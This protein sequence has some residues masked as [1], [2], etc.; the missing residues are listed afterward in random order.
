MSERALVHEPRRCAAKMRGLAYRL[1]RGAT[2][3]RD[4]QQSPD[5]AD[6]SVS[7]IRPAVTGTGWK[8]PSNL[9]QGWGAVQMFKSSFTKWLHEWETLIAT[10]INAVIVIGVAIFVTS[11]VTN[12]QKRTEFFI[13]F[14]KR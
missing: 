2:S 13:D 4:R 14:T 1:Q 9:V 10:F 12:S 7:G 3:Q 6:R 11:A 5:R 8:K